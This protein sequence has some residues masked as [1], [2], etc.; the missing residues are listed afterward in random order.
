MSSQFLSSLNPPSSNP[1]SCMS[2]IFCAKFIPNPKTQIAKTNHPFCHPFEV[3]SFKIRI[4]GTA[5]LFISLVPIG[6]KIKN[7]RKIKV[8]T[9]HTYISLMSSSLPLFNFRQER[10]V[11]NFFV[12]GYSFHHG[13]LQHFRNKI[14]MS[15]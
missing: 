13:Q 6:Q 8:V 1:T 2:D 10:L 12:F 11:H 4:D 7:H 9:I 15:L 14:T 3:M 5:A